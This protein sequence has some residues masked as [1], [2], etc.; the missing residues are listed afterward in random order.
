MTQQPAY[1]HLAD[2][3][4]FKGS[5]PLPLSG[6]QYGEVVFNTGMTGYV[7]SLTDP[8]YAGQIL[9]FTYPLVG[10]YGVPPKELWESGRLQ[11]SGVIMSELAMGPSHFQNERSLLAWLKA[12]KIPVITG[13]DTRALTKKIREHGVLLGA[14]SASAKPPTKFKDP[15]IE[16]LVATVTVEKKKIYGKGSKKIIAVDCG[17]KE[18]I[19]RCLTSLDATVVRVPYDY[20]Y[21]KEEFDGLFISNGPGDPARCT[22]TI[23]ILKK[24]LEMKKPIFG[25]CLGSQLLALAAGAST[26]KLRFGHRGH[27]QPC[28][29]S[30]NKHCVITSQNHGYAVDEKTI[31]RGWRVSYRNL[32]DGSV[33]GIAH[34]S[35]PY[36]SVQFHPEAAPGP[37]DSHFLFEKFYKLL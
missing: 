32:N 5:S 30:Q 37:T 1:L 13:I 22:A 21:T 11:P 9:T 2:G 17:M 6:H 27:N 16:D 14:I 4:H 36:F 34:E 19:V 24:A 23:E 28:Q 35:L 33:E 25:I 18:N 29:N 8:S 26:Y 20:D 15:N 31:P 7:E 3:S 10:N 12:E